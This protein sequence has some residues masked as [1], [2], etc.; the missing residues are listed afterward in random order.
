MTQK[1]LILRLMEGILMAAQEARQAQVVHQQTGTIGL[2]LQRPPVPVML[3]RRTMDAIILQLA[4][5]V[6]ALILAVAHHPRII[7]AHRLIIHT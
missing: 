2:H 3:W 5:V 7:T 1:I 6:R 4:L